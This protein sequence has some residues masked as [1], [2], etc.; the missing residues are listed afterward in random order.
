MIKESHSLKKLIDDFPKDLILTLPSLSSE[1]CEVVRVT[2]DSNKVISGSVFVAVSG[3]SRNG[4]DFITQAI[5]K[6]ASL[7]VCEQAPKGTQNMLRVHSSRLALAWLAA[8]FEG[9][10]T[11]ELKLVGVTG[12]S[13][14]TTTTHLM[15]SILEA[16]GERV[17]IIGT[18]GVRFGGQSFETTHTTPGPVEIQQFFRQMCD[19]GCTAAVVEVSSHALKQERIA[20]CAFDAVAF[21]NLSHEHLD[22]HSNMEDY[23]VSKR[24][25]ITRY[26][27]EAI[28]AGK[29]CV[30]LVNRDDPWGKRLA[31][32][33]C[34]SHVLSYGCDGSATYRAK[35]IK[36]SS[37]GIELTIEGP[38]KAS[39]TLQST[40]LGSFNASNI[41]C[42]ASIGLGLGFEE[43]NIQKGTQ[44]LQGVHGRLESVPNSHGILVLIDYAHKPDALE[45]VLV[46]LRELKPTATS[47]I[48]TVFG[49]GGDRDRQKRP[50]MGRIASNGSDIVVVTSDNPRT[51]DP[52]TIIAEIKKGV[53]GPARAVFEPDRSIAI[54][55][56]IAEAQKGDIVLIAGKGHEDYQVLRDPD[57]GPQATRKIHFNDRE[58]AQAV[59]FS[60]GRLALPN[61]KPHE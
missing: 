46:T 44:A 56:A 37:S 41:L 26:P 27:E 57:R 55:M 31:E 39:F 33:V 24:L 8:W 1:K 2:S 50:E 6:G 59:I 51:E 52:L 12:T 29:A 34:S 11:R 54:S 4:H 7:I 19:A 14:K 25:L 9:H 17:G 20:F 30:A 3:E 43:K 40:L 15:E 53:L 61:Q 48:I 58:V 49:C 42:A 38:D 36:L 32:E 5:Q 60:K 23:Y 18:N 35:K 13:G 16:C 45:K 28:K 10:P 21:T 47:R 22:Y